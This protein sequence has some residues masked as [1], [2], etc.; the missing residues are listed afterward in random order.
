MTLLV[1]SLAAVFLSLPHAL[2]LDNVAAAWAVAAWF[3]ALALRALVAVFG[4]ILTVVYVPSTSAFAVVSRWCAEDVLPTIAHSLPLKGH[5]LGALTIG[6]PALIL[7][8]SLGLVLCAVLTSARR[9]DTAM[10]DNAL[11]GGPDGSMILRDGA[12]FVGVVGLR[13][14]RVLVSAG[15]LVSLDDDELAASIAH[16]RGHIARRHRHVLLA[17]ELLRALAR[18][19]PGTAHAMREL[20]LHLERDADAYVLAQRH[21]PLALATAIGKARADRTAEPPIELRRRVLHLDRWRSD[22]H[23]TPTRLRA[24]MAGMLMVAVLALGALPGSA[25]A[26]VH[27]AGHAVPEDLC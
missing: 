15:A 8:A 9:L 24:A 10:A 17:A 26:G 11:P 6:G 7:L 16:E 25:A 2:A 20:R 21:D 23:A 5:L 13:R 12:V 14:P 18:V 1:A 3:A 22:G 4:A 19:V 27:A